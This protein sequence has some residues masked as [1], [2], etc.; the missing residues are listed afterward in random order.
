[1]VK[2]VKNV[3]HIPTQSAWIP[4]WH[5]GLQAE[6]FVCNDYVYPPPLLPEHKIYYILILERSDLHLKLSV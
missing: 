4:T 2:E 3:V 1:M 5:F 6:L